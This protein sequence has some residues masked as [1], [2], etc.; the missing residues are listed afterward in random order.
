MLNIAFIP[1][2]PCNPANVAAQ[3]CWDIISTF[4]VSTDAVPEK[5]ARDEVILVLRQVFSNTSF[6]SSAIP[7]GLVVTFEEELLPPGNTPPPTLVPQK[8]GQPCGGNSSVPTVLII[9]LALGGAVILAIACLII[10]GRKRHKDKVNKLIIGPEGNF[11]GELAPEMYADLSPFAGNDFLTD[12]ESERSPL[13]D[14]QSESQ[15]GDDFE[16]SRY[17]ASSRAIS[18][19]H[20]RGEG[21]W[22][23]SKE[24]EESSLKSVAKKEECVQNSVDGP[25]GDIDIEETESVHSDISDRSGDYD[26]SHYADHNNTSYAGQ[27]R[28]EFNEASLADESK[29][30]FPGG[31]F[32]DNKKYHCAEQSEEVT[33]IEIATAAGEE[34]HT[35]GK[36]SATTSMSSDRQRERIALK[37]ESKSESDVEPS[38][39]TMSQYNDHVI[40]DC[41]RESGNI[42]DMSSFVDEIFGSEN[43]ASKGS[44]VDGDENIKGENDH[45]FSD[46]SQSEESTSICEYNASDVEINVPNIADGIQDDEVGSSESITNSEIHTFNDSSVARQHGDDM[47][48]NASQ[49]DC[50]VIIKPVTTEYSNADDSHTDYMDASVDFDDDASYDRN[51]HLEPELKN[52]V[53]KYKGQT[54][55]FHISIN[56]FDNVERRSADQSCDNERTAEIGAAAIDHRE[57]FDDKHGK[58]ADEP[59]EIRHGYGMGTLNESSAIPGESGLLRDISVVDVLNTGHTGLVQECGEDLKLK[60]TSL[61]ES[62]SGND[63]FN[64]EKN[65]S[66]VTSADSSIAGANA[67]VTARLKA[68]G[69]DDSPEETRTVDWDESECETHVPLAPRYECTTIG[70]KNDD[71]SFQSDDESGAGLEQAYDFI[72][73]TEQVKDES[74]SRDDATDENSKFS[75]NKPNNDME[76]Y[77][78]DDDY[79]VSERSWTCDQSVPQ[80]GPLDHVL[81]NDNGNG[82]DES[83]RTWSDYGPEGTTLSRISESAEGSFATHIEDFGNNLI[84]DELR[85]M[86]DKWSPS[87]NDYEKIIEGINQTALVTTNLGKVGKYSNVGDEG[88]D[89]HQSETVEGTTQM[90]QT[91]PELNSSIHSPLLYS[92]RSGS[93]YEH[94]AP[95]RSHASSRSNDDSSFQSESNKS[96]DCSVD[97]EGDLLESKQLDEDSQSQTIRSYRSSDH[98][99]N[100]HRE[101]ISHS[102]FHDDVSLFNRSES[103]Q[104][105]DNSVDSQGEPI[106]HRSFHDDESYSQQSYSEHSFDGDE[107]SDDSASDHSETSTKP[108]QQIGMMTRQFP[109]IP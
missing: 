72:H 96:Y 19:D 10:R 31:S 5:P 61:K 16:D 35:E 101:S 82:D 58:E 44:Q 42:D 97:S 78:S 56:S 34:P 93:I 28:Q 109:R 77:S 49:T 4:V 73:G 89:S 67:I 52:A 40:E 26:G 8:Y 9:G 107:H 12:R 69:N 59:E 99:V 94:S 6:I 71:E 64:D 103:Y 104:T 45:F 1:S 38:V 18:H 68:E 102:S 106:L 24:V 108:Q 74:V 66:Y 70:L 20:S 91:P 43:D 47:F 7:A 62:D 84:N 30:G 105:D 90:G 29:E 55:P 25:S 21:A 95:C 87:G 92:E 83:E 17:T 86:D 11:S 14:D 79:S 53:D 37:S 88:E 22:E 51:E 23:T 75:L 98:S 27:A 46:S 100:S 3:S 50:T 80:M 36:R 60:S 15:H 33:A 65:I 48:Q 13:L 54:D 57:S 63:S 2:D 81:K 85:P 76:M 41:S 32:E 39:D